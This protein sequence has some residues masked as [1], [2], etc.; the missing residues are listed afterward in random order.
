[1]RTRTSLGHNTQNIG[2]STPIQTMSGFRPPRSQLEKKNPSYG[3]V[4]PVPS[5]ARSKVIFYSDKSETDDNDALM[6]DTPTNYDL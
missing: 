6:G 2:A 4:T 5:T 3:T 1:M